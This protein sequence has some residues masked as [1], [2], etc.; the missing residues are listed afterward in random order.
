MS[1]LGH[2]SVLYLRRSQPSSRYQ[3]SR[4]CSAIFASTSSSEYVVSFS[5]V[6]MGNRLLGG[7]Y[8]TVPPLTLMACP[9][10]KAAAGDASQTAAAATSAGVPQRF[11]GVD[12]ATSRLKSSS[13]PSPNAVSIQPGQRTLTRTAGASARARLLLKLS[14][15]PLTALK[16]SGFSP[17]IPNVTWSQ[18]MLTIVP[19]PGCAR[20]TSAT[21]YEHAIVPLRST[22]SRRSSL[23][24]HS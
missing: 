24:S 1:V 3:P 12:S 21:A 14:T 15:P 19:P 11:I 22:A 17:F 9:V 23:R 20:M 2:P 7:D 4:P 5:S 8:I 10:M 13:A 18:L 6:A 16:S